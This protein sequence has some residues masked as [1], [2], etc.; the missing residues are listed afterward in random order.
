MNHA[1]SMNKIISRAIHKAVPIMA[2]T[3]NGKAKASGKGKGTI[4]DI[5][6]EKLAFVS[7]QKEISDTLMEGMIHSVC[8]NRKTVTFGLHR[9]K[10]TETGAEGESMVYMADCPSF[11]KALNKF[12]KQHATKELGSKAACNSQRYVVQSSLLHFLS[13]FIS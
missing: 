13:I 5:S 1:E 11:I 9:R 12:I 10:K 6:A 7:A 3:G 4:Q 8:S 2:T